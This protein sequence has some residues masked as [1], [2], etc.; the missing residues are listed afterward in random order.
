MSNFG[1]PQKVEFW[2]QLG[3]SS[4]G[5]MAPSSTSCGVCRTSSIIMLPGQSGTSRT[6]CALSS[7]AFW[8][9]LGTRP[10]GGWKKPNPWLQSWLKASLP[11]LF[12]DR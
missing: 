7:R 4:R 12:S 2:N 11:A 5:L 3:H 1:T 8:S 10:T 6:P 9:T